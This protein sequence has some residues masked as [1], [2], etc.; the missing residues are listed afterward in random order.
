MSKTKGEPALNKVFLHDDSLVFTGQKHKI[1]L[2]PDWK[3]ILQ[4]NGKPYQY[5]KN[6]YPIELGKDGKPKREY[7]SV[8]KYESLGIAERPKWIASVSRNKILEK[9]VTIYAQG[10]FIQVRVNDLWNQ[11]GTRYR[12]GLDILVKTVDKNILSYNPTTRNPEAKRQRTDKER[13]TEAIRLR[14]R[15]HWSAC[16]YE[17]NLILPRDVG[18]VLIAE[19]KAEGRD[20]AESKYEGTAYIKGYKSKKSMKVIIYDMLEIHNQ[21]FVK[22]EV[23]LRQDYMKRNN[24]KDPNEW[25][26]QPQIQ[27]KILMTL[28]REWSKVIGNGEAFRMLKERLNVSGKELFDFM[29]KTENTLTAVMKRLDKVESNQERFES[30][31]ER[32]ESNQER[33]ERQLEELRKQGRA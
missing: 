8:K 11:F 2:D 5:G 12:E 20:Q 7:I 18:L 14:F 9:G 33:F 25:G 31:Q 23:T 4:A 17:H 10:S 15:K 19:I 21:E 1:G 30:N 27:E 6:I 22:I 3:G 16:K 29:G 26:T 28:K 32:F 24:L 13:K